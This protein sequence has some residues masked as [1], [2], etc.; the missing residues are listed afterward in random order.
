[1]TE[2]LTRLTAKLNEIADDNKLCIAFSDGV[3]ST[4]LLKVATNAGLEVFAVTI[5][6]QLTA[7]KTG[8]KKAEQTAKAMNATHKVIDID[9]L[10]DEKISKN[11]ELRCYYCKDKMFSAIKKVAL[12]NGFLKVCDGTNTDDLKEYRP[13]LKAKTDNG[14]YSPIADCGLSKQDVRNIAKELSLSVATK[15]SSPCFLTRFPY[16]TS[17]TSDLIIKVQKGEDIIKS[18][19]IEDC[20]LRIHSDIV[21]IEILQSDF[22]KLLK[23]KNEI[24]Y[25]LKSLG[26]IYITLDLGGL[27][28][29]SMDFKKRKEE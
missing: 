29:G 22:E 23:H 14:I 19:G 21:R 12:E 7:S 8:I 13:G 3:D 28:S 4:V 2:D 10:L 6:T 16:G 5:N 24:I 15:P 11:N 17:I 25:E 27:T 9:M 20:R 1:M 26:F 18:Y